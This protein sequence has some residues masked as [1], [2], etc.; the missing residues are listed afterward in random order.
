MA[1]AFQSIVIR[2]ETRIRLLFT[3]TLDTGAFGDPAPVFYI[4]TSTDG[5][6]LS[7]TVQTAYIVPNSPNV[8]ELALSSPLTKGATYTVSAIGVPCTDASSTPAG[9]VRPMLWGLTTPREN[10]EQTLVDRQRLLYG[11]D[12]LWNG[13]DFQET[14]TGDLDR[15][16]GPANVTKAL[17]RAIEANGLPWDADFGGK[18]REFVDS[19]SVAAGTLKGSVSAQILKD[20]R[21]KES[22]FSYS[23]EDASTFLFADVTLVSGEVVERVSIEVPN[24]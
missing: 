23:I 10:V 8:V 11:V 16:D 22:K 20:P 2:H 21:V 9:S 15:I 7:P 6:T 3:N 4:V 19:P 1:I 18:V 13:V 24:A 5:K 14:A 12:L 17:N